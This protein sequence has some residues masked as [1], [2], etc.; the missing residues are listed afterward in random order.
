MKNRMK[1]S[2]AVASVLLILGFAVSCGNT[3]TKE[4]QAP[5]TTI[6]EA[7][8]MG[9]ID[10]VDQHIAYGTDL[11]M[12]DDYGSTPLN[13]AATFGHTEVAKHLI[14]GGAD[15]NAVTA[16]GSTALHSASFFCHKDIV[17]AL[18]EGGI[19]INVRNNYGSTA[20]ESLMPPFSIV[21]GIYDQMGRDL[22]PLGIKFDYDE[23]EKLRPEIA[24]MIWTYELK[25]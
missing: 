7:A 18:L 6:H 24:E 21:K 23:I 8:F 22:G 5:K 12:K 25:R 17:E 3:K 13:I 20:R 1:T 4:E 16:D 9:N 11:N 19:D 14:E 15:L 10:E 2:L